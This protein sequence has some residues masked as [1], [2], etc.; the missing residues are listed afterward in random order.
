MNVTVGQHYIAKVAGRL[1]VVRLDNVVVHEP[2]AQAFRSKGKRT[3]YH[4]TNLVTKRE[5]SFHS[6]RKFRREARPAEVTAKRVGASDRCGSCTNCLMLVEVR[7]ILMADLRAAT[8]DE[9]KSIIRGAW[10]VA[11]EETPCTG[12]RN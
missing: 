4:C 10:S 6:A 8:T 9:E 2:Y 5:T 12:A 3:S 1:T 7:A 11:K